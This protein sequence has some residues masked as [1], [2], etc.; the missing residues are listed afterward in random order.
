MTWR[1]SKSLPK[2]LSNKILEHVDTSGADCLHCW[3]CCDLPPE[4]PGTI[5]EEVKYH[6]RTVLVVF[7][8]LRGVDFD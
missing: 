2:R 6:V 7:T 4:P 1:T 5:E 8:C 3:H